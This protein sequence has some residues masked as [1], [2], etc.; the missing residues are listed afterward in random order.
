[1]MN[2]K[3][4]KMIP[5]TFIGIGYCILLLLVC[6]M[7]TAG[8]ITIPTEENSTI[9]FVQT[10]GEI[11]TLPGVAE[12]IVVLN[13]NAVELLAAI[14]A[15]DKVIGVSQAV[16]THPERQ[17]LFPEAQ[18]VGQ[19]TTPDA[20]LIIKLDPDVIIAFDSMRP[21]NADVLEQSGI[22]IVYIDCYKPDTMH[23]DVTA[24]GIITGKTKEANDY[25]EFY[26]SILSTITERIADI[27]ETDYPIVYVE[28]SSDYDIQG[29]NISSD[30][31]L[32]ITGG[33]NV[34]T[35]P[36]IGSSTHVSDEW[37]VSNNPDVMIKMMTAESLE[38]IEN[39]YESLLARPGASSMKAVSEK[40]VFILRNDMTYGPRLFAGAALMA[41]ILHP[42]EFADINVNAL[43]DEY[44]QKFNL[45][46]THDILTYPKIE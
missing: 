23:Q 5:H 10:N 1:M 35:Y 16:K 19:S 3:I 15:G 32:N 2:E 46:F 38:N 36:I 26:D 11:T 33:K 39:T 31:L 14:G 4:D 37:I 21:K 41:K 18:S 44:N 30:M 45:N 24:L 17:Y 22:P 13:A 34:L 29:P 40:Q 42:V 12:K 8:C 20:E 43:L 7:L 9:M 25:L 28:F 6:M 27:P